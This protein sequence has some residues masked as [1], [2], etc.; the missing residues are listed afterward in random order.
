MINEIRCSN[1]GK[2]CKETDTYCKSCGEPI[3]KSK[4]T[5]DNSLEGIEIEKWEEFI[6]EGADKY[7][8]DFRKNEGKKVFTSGN[9][10]AFFFGQLWFAY[11]KMYLETLIIYAATFLVVIGVL[12]I[13]MADAFTGVMVGIPI[14]LVSRMAMWLFAN[15]IYKAHIKREIS[16]NAPDMRKGGTNIIYPIVCD[17][18]FGAIS[19]ILKVV[20]EYFL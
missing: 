18:I 19:S 16:K 12:A 7:I 8:S 20:M 9:F 10:G 5:Y 13:T 15:A 3:E 4:D 17:L 11:R 2:K 6:G 14:L 1:C